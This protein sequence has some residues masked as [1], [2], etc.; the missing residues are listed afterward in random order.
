M[1]SLPVPTTIDHNGKTLRVI[2][3]GLADLLEHAQWM[4]DQHVNEAKKQMVGLPIDLAKH[5]YD[6]ARKEASLI[7]IGTEEY[8]EAALDFG[9]RVYALWLSIRKEVKDF[10]VALVYEI[11]AED[12]GRAMG[13]SAESLGF[14]RPDPTKPAGPA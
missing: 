2:P 8:R 9:G 12:M 14:M 4:R 1:P 13:V 11:F 10:P 6:E 5:A 7:K 3:L